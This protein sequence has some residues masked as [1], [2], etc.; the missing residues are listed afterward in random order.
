MQGVYHAARAVLGVLAERVTAGEIDHVRHVLPEA[1]R[2]F[3]PEMV[4]SR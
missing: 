4:R 1:V 3:W 2:E